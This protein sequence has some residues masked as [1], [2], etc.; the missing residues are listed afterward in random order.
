M[1]DSASGKLKVN[2]AS[3]NHQN[4]EV[5]QDGLQVK[6]REGSAL[7]STAGGLGVNVDQSTLT[8]EPGVQGS[9]GT[10]VVDTIG[11]SNITISNNYSQGSFLG[12]NSTLSEFEWDTVGRAQNPAN[13]TFIDTRAGTDAINMTVNSTS[14]LDLGDSG[15]ALSI[16]ANKRFLNTPVEVTSTGNVSVDGRL[17]NFFVFKGATTASSTVTAF[18]NYVADGQQIT[19]LNIRT[20][21]SATILLQDS[22]TNNV[23][24]YKGLDMTLTYGSTITLVSY[25]GKVYET[26]RSVN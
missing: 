7:T 1:T 9:P 15:G 24:L 4:L 14:M 21:P 6:N 22:T 17:G 23:H 16:T 11:A 2:V 5:V 20:A 26:S 19:I 10:L 25:G 3:T 8:I 13:T 12:Y 18:A